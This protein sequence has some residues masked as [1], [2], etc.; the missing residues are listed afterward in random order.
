LAPPAGPIGVG[1]GAAGVAVAAGA[2]W[3]ASSL[4]G[5]VSRIDLGSR[6]V[7]RTVDVCGGPHELAVGPGAVW[8]T[9]HAR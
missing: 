9:T 5:T 1:R 2:V 7:V 4:D 3:V 6:R 8:V